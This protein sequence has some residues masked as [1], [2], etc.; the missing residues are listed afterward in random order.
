MAVPSSGQLRLRGD[1]ALE[2]D[3]VATGINVSLRTL[4]AAAGKSTPD[5]MSEFY[6]YSASVPP[7]VTTGSS[8]STN[9]SVYMTGTVNS[10]GGATITERGFYFGTSTNPTSNPKYIVSGTTGNFNLNRTGLSTNTTYRYWA[11]AK[12][13]SGTTIGAM[14]TRATYP[15]LNY[16][17]QYI[18]QDTQQ[19]IYNMKLTD[20]NGNGVTAYLYD[21]SYFHHPYLGAIYYSTANVSYTGDYTGGSSNAQNTVGRLN[22]AGYNSTHIFYTRSLYSPS[23]WLTPNAQ[24]YNDQDSFIAFVHPSLSSLNNN[25]IISSSSWSNYC[26]TGYVYYVSSQE[27]IWNQDGGYMY[28][29]NQSTAMTV[30]GG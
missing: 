29:G 24:F 7:T 9:T 1:I 10:D 26:S 20:A 5:N 30:L 13:A 21:A 11:Y 25:S 23:S 17:W 6:G 18:N 8:S 12:N 16:S 2:V 28:Q 27:T 3:G 4:S 14:Q 19:Y 15:T 22:V